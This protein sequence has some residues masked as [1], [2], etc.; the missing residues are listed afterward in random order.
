MKNEGGCN[1]A[2]V[3]VHAVDYDYTVERIID[4]A[5]ANEP[6]SVS[7]LAVH[8]V[9][10]GVDDPVHRGRLNGLDLVTPDGQ[11]V[12]WALRWLHGIKLADRVYGPNLM[13]Q[14]VAQAAEK[15]LAIYLFGGT[16]EILGELTRK[17][18]EKHPDLMIRSEASQFRT[19][20][21]AERDALVARIRASGTD[22]VFVGL[23]CPRQEIFVS[24]MAKDVGLPMLACG[25]AFEYL[26]EI[27]TEP[28]EWVQKSGLQ[29]FQRLL[30]DP[31]RLWHRYLVLN[32]RFVA[33]ILAQYSGLWN[34]RLTDTE[35]AGEP[36][37]YG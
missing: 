34:P 21:A 29:W 26:A 33:R 24:E 20:D 28:P 13:R 36:V 17:I 10:T 27:K 14:T 9:M 11:P 35:P 25:A 2:G 22:V 15:G 4:A 32:P 12:R 3:R 19:L 23:G 1:I 30:T 8:G 31:R 7:A 16:E 37:R 5:V 6:L 18:E